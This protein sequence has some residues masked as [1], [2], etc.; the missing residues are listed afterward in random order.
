MIKSIMLA[1]LIFF[2]HSSFALESMKV[3]SPGDLDVTI[4]ITDSPQFIEEWVGTPASH[5]PIITKINK[6]KFNQ[7]VHAGFAITGYSRLNQEVDFVVS[8]QVTSPVGSVLLN[9]KKWAVHKQKVLG[10]KGIIIAD[11]I[12]DMTFETSDPAG[13]YTIAATVTDNISGKRV[14]N[15]TILKIY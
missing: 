3:N 13:N 6:A 10:D 15:S 4:F 2:P 9:E 7:M 1:L 14:S 8:V 11:P 12:L 5:A